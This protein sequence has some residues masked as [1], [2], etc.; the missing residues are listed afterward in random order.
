VR[1]K[2]SPTN[3]VITSKVKQ[4]L[5]Y[6]FECLE[7]IVIRFCGCRALLQDVWSALYTMYDCLIYKIIFRYNVIDSQ[8]RVRCL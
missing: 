7:T 8:E 1:E 6:E 2:E 5:R 4:Y 3:E